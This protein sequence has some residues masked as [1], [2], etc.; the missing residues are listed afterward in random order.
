MDKEQILAEIEDLRLKWGAEFFNLK[1]QK[2]IDALC[3][4]NNEGYWHSEAS[5]DSKAARYF[6]R[7]QSLNSMLFKMEWTKEVTEKRIETW[8]TEVKKMGKLIPPMELHKL[9]KRLGYNMDQLRRANKMIAEDG[10]K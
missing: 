2:N 8:N 4:E 6:E 7:M 9:A 5:L 3:S 1:G 10:T